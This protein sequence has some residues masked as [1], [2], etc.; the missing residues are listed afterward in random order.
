[1]NN[2]DQKKYLLYDSIIQNPTKC[3]PKLSDRMQINNFKGS[4]GE[5]E[6]QDGITK[7]HKETLR[8]EEYA[9]YLDCGDNFIVHICQNINF[10]LYMQF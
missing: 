1:M 8:D 9:H 6:G 3:K 4:G 2:P 10:T 7:G 5:G